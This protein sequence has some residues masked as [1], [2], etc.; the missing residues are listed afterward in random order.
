MVLLITVTLPFVSAGIFD[1]FKK[2]VKLAPQEA[3]T[4]VSNVAPEIQDPMQSITNPVPAAGGTDPVNIVFRVRDNNGNAD[5][6]DSTLTIDT[7]YSGGGEAPRDG[8]ILDCSVTPIGNNIKEYDCNIDIYY[9]DAAGIWDIVIYI[10]DSGG[11]SDTDNDDTFTVPELKAIDPTPAT[12]DFGSVAPAQTDVV[13]QSPTTITN[14]GN[15]NIPVD[16]GLELRASA[17]IGLTTST[18]TIP[19]TSF[20]SADTSEAGTVCSIGGVAHDGT[21]LAIPAFVLSKGSVATPL[22]TRE[23]PHC[24]VIVPD[25]LSSQEYSTTGTGGQAW[26]FQI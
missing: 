3:R 1:M 25:P 15:F 17:L 6:D 18:E 4:Q 2:D 26:D 22:P 10:E 24:L 7:D 14:E 16:T 8:T 23:I 20:R 12:I 13:S 9:Y 21:Y 11:L 5:I 19:V